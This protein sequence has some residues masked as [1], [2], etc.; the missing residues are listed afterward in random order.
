MSLQTSPKRETAPRAVVFVDTL[1][2][3]T[4]TVYALQQALPPHSALRVAAHV[5][6]PRQVLGLEGS[7]ITSPSPP[8]V[9]C[10]Y[11]QI[12]NK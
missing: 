7:A 1:L 3:V 12:F 4:E 6:F 2:E 5:G 8:R 9:L 10:P 11:P